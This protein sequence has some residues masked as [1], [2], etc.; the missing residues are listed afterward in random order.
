MKTRLAIF[1]AIY[2]AFSGPW[3]ARAE[4]AEDLEKSAALHFERGLE[5]YREGSLDAALVEFERAYA[6]IPNYRLLYNL[7]QIQAER[8]EYVAAVNLFEKYLAAGGTELG[9]T[10][11]AEAQQE[12]DKLRTRISYL[13]VESNL[14]GA[15]LFVNDVQV[16]TLPLSEALPINSGVCNVRLERAGYSPATAQL[17]VAGGERPRLNLPLVSSD[18]ARTGEHGAAPSKEA[19][20]Q[21][22]WISAASTLALGGATLGLGLTARA[23]DEDLDTALAQV[24][25]DDAEVDDARSRLKLCA[26]LTDA[27]AVASVASLGVALYFLFAP[28]RAKGAGKESAHALRISPSTRGLGLRATF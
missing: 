10:R 17:K 15:Q 16:A 22:F 21:P 9:E 28:P 14:A 26:A 4:P 8:H 11:R 18:Q 12:V 20:Y 5:L 7:A 27:F 1:M 25:V 3:S 6:L 13:T 19:N 23:A 2:L 24:P